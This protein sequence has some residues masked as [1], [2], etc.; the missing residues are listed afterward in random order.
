MTYDFCVRGWKIIQESGRLNW[1]FNTETHLKYSLLFITL[2]VKLL[3]FKTIC[4]LICGLGKFSLFFMLLIFCSLNGDFLVQWTS[5]SASVPSSYEIQSHLPDF[6]C[7][8]FLSVIPLSFLFL[9]SFKIS[10]LPIE[11]NY[12]FL[13]SP[14]P[15][16][17]TPCLTGHCRLIQHCESSLV[18]RW[19]LPLTVELV[20]SSAWPM[21][22]PPWAPL[23]S[24]SLSAHISVTCG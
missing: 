9:F 24:P 5:C 19:L 7:A 12:I 11:V 14:G 1:H 18:C 21:C 6:N 22:G 20:S 17:L 15:L 4:E 23:S 13:F 3:P 16:L 10:F 2:I 8:P